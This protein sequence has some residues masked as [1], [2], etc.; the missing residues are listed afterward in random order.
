MKILL[1]SGGMDSWLI[2]K[3]WKPDIKLYIDIEGDYNQKEI[4]RLPKSV[5]IIKFSLLGKFED[6]KTKYIPMRNLFFLMIASLY[7]NEICFG[8][9][10]GDYGSK[11]KRLKFI[12]K[13]ENI[14]NYCIGN[15]S[16]T[17]GRKIVLERRFVKMS[18][19]DLAEEYLRKGGSIEK[20]GNESYSCF[21]NSNGHCY[22]CKPC[23]RRFIVLYEYGYKFSKE[24]VKKM[25][26][27]MKM[28]VI[29]KSKFYGTYYSKKKIEGKQAKKT[30]RKLF[31]K[32]GLKVR[33]FK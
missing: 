28:N 17:K 20:L 8:A 13:A 9:T 25:I 27:Y 14:I 15:Q 12:N 11:D 4:K 23:F 1:Y 10:A 30:V 18:K 24:K 2:D 16:N 33:D 19:Y 26:E 22:N 6:K 5:K 3:L 21:N 29:P 31:E 32:Y 7:G